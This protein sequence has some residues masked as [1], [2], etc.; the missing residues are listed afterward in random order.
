MKLLRIAVLALAAVGAAA[1]AQDRP[2]FVVAVPPL[3]IDTNKL[4]SAGHTGV[5]VKQVAELIAS[6]LRGTAD[7]VPIGPEGLKV[8][9]YPEAT[10]PSFAYWR[11]KGAKGLVTGFITVRSDDRLMFGCYVHDIPTGRE[12]G[13]QGFVIDADQWRSAAH[14]CSSLAFKSLTG[15]PGTFDATIAYVAES[16]TPQ[17]RVKRI[18]IMDSDG[19]NH[20]YLTAGDSIVASPRLSPDGELLA[21]V[22][23]PGGRSQVRVIDVESGASRFVGPPDVMSFAPRWAPDGSGILFSIA[24]LGNTDIYF[25]KLD[26]GGLQRLTGTPGI[27]TSASFSPDGTRIVFSSDRSGTPQLYTMNS[28]GSNQR[29]LT[30]GGGSYESPVWSPDGERIAF[31]LARPDGL[32]IG[33]MDADGR[34]VRSL[35]NGPLDE[36]PSWSAG[37]GQIL[38]QRADPSGRSVLARVTLNGDARTILTPQGASD[39]DWPSGG[40]Q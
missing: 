28:D 31:A 38:F 20:R 40:A 33:V 16:G 2:T 39:P 34:N 11:T 30:F 17:Q 37:G 32:R 12:L 35:T 8:Y 27:D 4:T 21:Y 19:S 9:P 36:G 18:A 3:A 5:L 13:R 15:R 1:S 10:A 7:V 25:A 29:R 14:R 6:D 22:S 24:E 23:Y 26:S